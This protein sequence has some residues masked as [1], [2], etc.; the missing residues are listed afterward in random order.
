[1]VEWRVGPGEREKEQSAFGEGGA[2]KGRAQ[3]IANT[4]KEGEHDIDIF[5]DKEKG[6][7]WVFDERDYGEPLGKWGQRSSQISKHSYSRAKEIVVAVTDVLGLFHKQAL[8]R[9]VTA[10]HIVIL[11]GR[12]VNRPLK[13]VEKPHWPITPTALHFRAALSLTRLIVIDSP[14][15]PR[16][17]PSP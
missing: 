15:G 12:Q 7:E 1:M 6:E 13:L 16:Q 17:E 14:G 3:S 9:P 10:G 5:W 11:I 8:L 2:A 4:I